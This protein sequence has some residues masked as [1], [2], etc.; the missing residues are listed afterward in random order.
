MMTDID[1]I[2]ATRRLCLQHD[3]YSAIDLARRVQHPE[4]RDTLVKICNS[5]CKA[6]FK[7]HV[8]EYR[9]AS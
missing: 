7:T 1:I 9:R 8:Q 4:T 3:F 5:F 6:Q 2:R